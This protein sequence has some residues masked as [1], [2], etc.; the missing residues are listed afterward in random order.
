M[1]VMKTDLEGEVI[2]NHYY[3]PATTLDAART[4][5]WGFDLVETKKNGQLGYRVV[6]FGMYMD[7][8]QPANNR[9]RPYMVQLSGAGEKLWDH[10]DLA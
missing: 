10:L 8:A 7:E 3:S 6:G 1:F 5:S 4:R 9:R 2:W